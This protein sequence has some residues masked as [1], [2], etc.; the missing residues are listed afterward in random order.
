MPILRASGNAEV[1]EMLY[2]KLKRY[3]VVMPLGDKIGSVKGVM[4]DS[5]DWHVKDVV[6]S[7]GL[8]KKVRY[9]FEDVK[10]VDDNK[11]RIVMEG[12]SSSVDKSTLEYLSMDELMK[13]K[14]FSDDEKEIG[15]IYDTVIT[16]KPEYWKMD[17]ILIYHGAAK[18]RL[19][20]S[21]SDIKSVT[22]KILLS[23]TYK[24]VEGLKEESES[25]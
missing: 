14:I 3:K 6:V 16:T 20:I 25:S 10:N 17:K 8:F 4:L 21:Y 19:R 1:R 5:K 13:K 23:K 7:S 22:D 9:S 11:M 15:K 2:S 12:K 24:E 18:R